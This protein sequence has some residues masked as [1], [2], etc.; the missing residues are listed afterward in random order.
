M[1]PSAFYTVQYTYDRAAKRWA[2]RFTSTEH[3]NIALVAPLRDSKV[4][5]EGENVICDSEE[6]IALMFLQFVDVVA[7]SRMETAAKSQAPPAEP[8]LDVPAQE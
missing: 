5:I 1:I 6:D 8:A 7:A 2:A 3:E 4:Y